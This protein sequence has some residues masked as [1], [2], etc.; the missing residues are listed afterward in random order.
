MK[1]DPLSLANLV[2]EDRNVDTLNIDAMDSLQIVQTLNREDKK[3]ALAVEQVLPEIAL[4]VDAI[5]GAFAAGGRLIYIGAGTSGR[6]GVLDAVECPPTFSVHDSLVI[7]LMAG[8]EDAM[9]KAKEGAEDDAQAGGRDLQ[10]I[11][12]SAVD[13]VVGIA[14]SGRT[15]YVLGALEYARSLG[16]TTVGLACN[17]QAALIQYCD[18]TILP[19]VGPEVLTGSTRLK[20]GTAQK[21]VLNMLSTAA[22]VR[23]GKVYENLMVDVRVSNEK[24]R[25]RARRIVRLLGHCTDEQAETALA[26]SGYRCKEA[27]VMVRKGLD[28]ASA[29]EQLER[30]GGHLR[31][32]LAL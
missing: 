12:L 5:E 28:V 3:V 13:V 31:Q 16:C 8:G 9:F 32:A 26:Q 15:P 4:A 6:L 25:M 11:Q 17:P 20:A 18:I 30:V 7:G 10:A 14:A 21:L 24:L 29:E 2:S 1:I 27:I 19:L 23:I 22:M